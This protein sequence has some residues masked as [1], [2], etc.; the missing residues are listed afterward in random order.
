MILATW[1]VNSLGARL[2]R[3]EEWVDDVQPDIL[4]LQ[5]TKLAD[6]DFPAMLFGARGYESIHVGQGQWNGVAICSRVGLEDPVAGFA[7][8]GPPD[9]EA[10]VVTARCGGLTVVSVYVPNGRSP[11]HE[12]FRYK[13]EFLERLARHVETLEGPVVVAGDFN[14]APEDRD[15]WDPAAFEGATHVTPE[16]RAALGRL[17]DLGLEDVFRRHHT[18]GGLYSWWD[19]RGGSFHKRQGMRIDLVLASTELASR[20]CWALIDRNAR[21]GTQPSDHAPVM[22][23][24]RDG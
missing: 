20:S 3:V 8:G 22:V 17:L 6:G 5:E 24:F 2:G 11:T 12:Q 9:P 15:V 1:N 21:K 13:L 14:I 10:R 16:E 19:Y 4:C 23:A 18:A 7:D